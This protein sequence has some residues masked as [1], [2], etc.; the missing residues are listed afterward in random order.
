[1]AQSVVL[2]FDF[3]ATEMYAHQLT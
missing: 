2:L 1:M 3:D